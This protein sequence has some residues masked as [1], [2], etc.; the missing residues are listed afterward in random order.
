M[1]APNILNR[2]KNLLP[3]PMSANVMKQTATA[4]RLMCCVL[5]PMCVCAIAS[6]CVFCA[7]LACG[8][9]VYACCGHNYTNQAFGEAHA[10]VH[11]ICAAVRLRRMSILVGGGVGWSCALSLSSPDIARHRQSR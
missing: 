3:L 8:F 1:Y 11:A 7:V 9:L 2:V 5:S 6:M 4:V 10:A